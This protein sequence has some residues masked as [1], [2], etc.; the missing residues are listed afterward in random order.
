M[1]ERMV[2]SFFFCL[3]EEGEEEDVMQQAHIPYSQ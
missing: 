1:G 3:E 2:P